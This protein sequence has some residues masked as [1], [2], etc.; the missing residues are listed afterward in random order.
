MSGST[1]VL[2]RSFH[3]LHEMISVK[4]VANNGVSIKTPRDC[5]SSRDVNPLTGPCDG[6]VPSSSASRGGS[7]RKR[8]LFLGHRV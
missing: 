2:V 6:H 4:M 5:N 7:P 1:E 3:E 8:P